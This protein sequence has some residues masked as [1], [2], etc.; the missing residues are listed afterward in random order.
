MK[1][2]M[3]LLAR[4]KWVVMAWWFGVKDGLERQWLIHFWPVLASIQPVFHPEELIRVDSRSR[5]FWS[6]KA[7]NGWP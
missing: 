1:W 6:Q 5:E 7:Q 4:R 2:K 3:R